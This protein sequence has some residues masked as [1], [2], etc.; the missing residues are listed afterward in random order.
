MKRRNYFFAVL[1]CVTLLT[2][3]Q[4]VDLPETVR[5][6]SSS[7]AQGVGIQVN[8]SGGTTTTEAGGA[9]TFAVSL[10][11]KPTANVTVTL[12]SS[13]T[14]EGQLKRTSGTCDETG[15]VAVGSCTLTFT[16]TTWLNPQNVSVV[17]QNDDYA[18]GN[19]A[20]VINFTAASA[21]SAYNS[22]TATANLTNNDNDTAGFVATPSSGLVT[23]DDG[24]IAT[25]KIKL[26]SRPTADVTFTVM[27]DN[28]SAG[29]VTTPGTKSFTFTNGNWSTEQ[30]LVV[31]GAGTIAAYKIIINGGVTSS[32]ANYTG[33]TGTV[34]HT[35]IG[36]QNVTAGN[37]FIFLTSSA[38]TGNLGG[39]AG[40]DA[41]CNSAGN[42]P[43]GSTYKAMIAASGVRVACTTAN[44]GGGAGEHIDWVLYPTTQYTR[45]DN[46]AIGTTTANGIFAF[47][48]TASISTASQS[49]WTGLG[50]DWTTSSNCSSWG[51]T[52]GNGQ[53]GLAN[54]TSPSAIN[55]GFGMGSG[56]TCAAMYPIYCAEQ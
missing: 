26:S 37:K 7:E 17:G 46:T 44:C 9:V 13:N 47:S 5:F 27:S 6:V 32:D 51:S 14:A 23:K 55:A 12:T 42:K 56:L 40:A 48:L 50:A 41:K 21:D 30:N 39:I 31:T 16:D 2:A 11:T 33:I 8:L 34:L 49:P 43:N 45:P 15:G 25:A 3:C 38:Y 4:N 18:D 36:V 1:G 20:Y 19:K 22:Q 35:G 29:D 10:N 54:A 24:S 52:G 28:T 53:A